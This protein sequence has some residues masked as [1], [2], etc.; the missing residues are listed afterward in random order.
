[1]EALEQECDTLMEELANYNVSPAEAEELANKFLAMAYRINRKVRDIRNDIIKLSLLERNAYADAFKQLD[2]KLSVSKQ[3]A[4]AS[5]DR[6]FLRQNVLLQ[7]TSNACEYW[8]GNYDVFEK[9]HIFYKSLCR[10]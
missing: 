2:D 8:R 1:M 6:N 5:S 10:D 4:L 3:K 9:A 7:K